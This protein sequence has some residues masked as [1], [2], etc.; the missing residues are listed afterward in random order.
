MHP[1]TRK[2]WLAVARYRHEHGRSPSYDAISRAVGLARSNVCAHV[3]TLVRL[4]F[5]GHAPSAQYALTVFV[6]PPIEYLEEV[7]RGSK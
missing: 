5:L 4:G 1:S 2:V 7:C 6:W 3:N